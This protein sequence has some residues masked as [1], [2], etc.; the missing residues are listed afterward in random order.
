MDTELVISSDLCFDP[1]GV[2]RSLLDKAGGAL[3]LQQR[4][5]LA[6]DL[7]RQRV[8]DSEG[9]VVTTEK[10]NKARRNARLLWSPFGYLKKAS[11]PLLLMFLGDSRVIGVSFDIVST[12][13]TQ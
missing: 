5:Q 6:V 13:E 4:K 1:S 8:A 7:S 3:P 11:H 2:Q 12:A 10:M 9:S